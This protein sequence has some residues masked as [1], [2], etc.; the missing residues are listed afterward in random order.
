MLRSS[1]YRIGPFES[2]RSLD[3]HD[4]VPGSRRSETHPERGNIVKAYVA[5]SEPTE[6]SDS[7]E[8]KSNPHL[9]A[10]LSGHGHSRAIEF[11]DEL[12]EPVTGKI[13]RTALRDEA[14]K[15]TESDSEPGSGR[16]GVANTS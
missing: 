12:P 9:H 14:E 8:E 3:E 6:P 15:E 2:D 10:K 13:R 5:L 7:R 1:N 16:D 11:R 4:G